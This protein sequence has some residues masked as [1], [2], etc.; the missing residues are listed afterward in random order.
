[1]NRPLPPFPRPLP[2]DQTS[3]GFLFDEDGQPQL[4]PRPALVESYRLA[5]LRLWLPTGA[6][7]DLLPRHAVAAAVQPAEGSPALLESIVG[8]HIIFPGPDA[9]ETLTAQGIQW[10]RAA[11]WAP[12]LDWAKPGVMVHGLGDER[13][14]ELAEALGLQVWLQVCPNGLRVCSGDGRLDWLPR[15]AVVVRE[16]T[17]GC[18]LRAGLDD[19]CVPRGGP[20]TSQSRVAFMMWQQHRRMLV[21]ALGCGVCHGGEVIDPRRTVRVQ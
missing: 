15:A 5:N 11:R 14:R 8:T 16:A 2:A 6:V 13:M 7:V 3:V 9:L 12:S 19:F 1:M 18:P 10:N 4:A 20:W 17:L 21:E